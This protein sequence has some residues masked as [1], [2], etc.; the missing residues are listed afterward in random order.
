V[1]PDLT[2][3]LA[4]A[5]ASGSHADAC[6]AAPYVAAAEAS[7]AVQLDQADCLMLSLAPKV[8][9]A[10]AEEVVARQMAEPHLT[11]L[12]AS[13]AASTVAEEQRVGQAFGLPGLHELGPQGGLV[14]VV[15]V[16][17]QQSAALAT[18]PPL[19]AALAAVHSAFAPAVAAPAVA[20][21]VV[22]AAAVAADSVTAAAVGLHR[23]CIAQ[24]PQLL[25]AGLQIVQAHPAADSAVG[26]AISFW[27][28]FAVQQIWSS[29][30]IG[31]DHHA[32]AAPVVGTSKVSVVTGQKQ[33]CSQMSG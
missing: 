24:L 15:Q 28:L 30:Q 6:A 27:L 10:Q 11:A 29:R 17:V 5:D 16:G 23:H 7:A 9:V 19:A 21:A 13:V 8:E 25:E 32:C 1:A 22:A 33:R 26:G 31:V 2:V 14:G 4:H 12:S 20:A 3:K 18:A